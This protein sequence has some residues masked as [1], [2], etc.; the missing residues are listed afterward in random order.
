[1]KRPGDVVSV[2]GLAPRSQLREVYRCRAIV[3]PPGRAV[4][5]P[6]LSILQQV[7]RSILGGAEFFGVRPPRSLPRGSCSK[8]FSGVAFGFGS[9]W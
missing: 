8:G 3:T 7:S 1:M 2:P 6:G 4:R 5:L 9:A